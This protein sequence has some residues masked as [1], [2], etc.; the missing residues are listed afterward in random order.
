VSA[1][2]TSYQDGR[3]G[4]YSGV[5]MAD[6]L[7]LPYLSSGLCH[8]ILTCSPYHARHEQ[9]H[10]VFEDNE[11]IDTG[12]AIHDAL[13]EGVD[14]IEAIR[15]EDH[16]SKP[17][18]ANPEGAIP[19]GWT[20]NAIKAARDAA[21]AAGKIPMLAG[22]VQNI[23]NAVEA[24]REFIDRSELAGLFDDGQPE[25]TIVWDDEGVIC[26]ARPDWLS[27]DH[28]VLCHV[29]TT[30]GSAHPEAW[31]RSQLV[32]SGYDV[33]Y[34]FYERGLYSL[35]CDGRPALTSVFLVIEQSAPYGC[36]L[37]ALD[38][39][40]MDIAER[41]VARA[42]ATWRQCVATN[43]WPCYP[44]RI[45]YASPKPWQIAEEEERQATQEFDEK[46]A[47]YGLQV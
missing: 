3:P 20:N 37:I 32:T 43:R 30:Q 14:R 7:A 4:I 38:P 8:T 26:R 28:G 2:L 27:G 35:P 19:K 11:A 1:P 42:I 29:K 25:A 45:A 16:R 6:Y 47:E 34:A 13:L 21:R 40:M 31:I 5:P 22:E 10:R 41:K 46:Q 33:A 17:T 18:K 15:P 44:A 9:Q 39:A 23:K 24:A 36:S 12:V